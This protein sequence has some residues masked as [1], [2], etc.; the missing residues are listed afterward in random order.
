M[1]VDF[2]ESLSYLSWLVRLMAKRTSRIR[3]AGKVTT[4]N[5]ELDRD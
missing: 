1:L 2:S 4:A 5:T 3:G